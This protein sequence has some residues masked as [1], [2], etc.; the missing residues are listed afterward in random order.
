MVWPLTKPEAE[1]NPEHPI[2]Q[3]RRLV[4]E[5]MAF[6]ELVSDLTS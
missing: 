1:L 6:L 5:P 4:T 3:L 2:R